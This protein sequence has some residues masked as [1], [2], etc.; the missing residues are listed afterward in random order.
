MQKGEK[1]DLKHLLF[2]FL[3]SSEL[4]NC[5]YLIIYSILQHEQK[6]KNMFV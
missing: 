5:H 3:F 6:A 4:F 1:G 2:T